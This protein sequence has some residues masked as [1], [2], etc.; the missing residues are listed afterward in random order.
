MSRKVCVITGTRADYGLLKLLIKSLRDEPD[1]SL[2][3]VVTGM[4][5]SPEFGLTYR[6][7]EQDGFHIDQKIE[8][9]TSSDTAVGTT[10]SVGLAVIGFADAYA[11]LQPDIV[12]VLGDRFEILAAV[13]A[14]LFAKIPVVH[15]HGGE[16]TEGAYD[17]AIRH[18]ITKLSHFHFV[19]TAEYRD[20]VIQMGELPKRVHNVGG[21][22]V[23]AIKTTT[24]L[25]RSELEASL[26]FKF[27][28][29]NLLVTFHPTTMDTNSGESQTEALLNSLAKL[30]DTHLIFTHPNA[31]TG[32]RAM[33]DMIEH[34]VLEHE[35]ARVFTSLGQARY[36]SC[37]AQVDGVIG[38]SSSGLLEAPSFRV[39]TVNIG[40][41][42]KGRASASSVIHCEPS[43]A[44]ISHAI[45]RL[46]STDFQ[47]SLTNVENPYGQGG[48]VRKIVETLKSLSFPELLCKTFYDFGK[49]DREQHCG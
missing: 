48:A 15:I 33:I 8:M 20:R 17:D 43:V 34:F 26:D 28:K 32:S 41:R 46:Y 24:F 9:L 36:L 2:Q 12:L 23:D 31:D 19:A 6:E 1:L 45:E 37:I 30:S 11:T 4:H 18:A 25:S 27:G 21:L 3:L 35:H 14:A 5:L 39:G 47:R 44:S 49:T 29:K 22:G 13:T 38:N 10:K 16:L 42:Q 40:D 7:I